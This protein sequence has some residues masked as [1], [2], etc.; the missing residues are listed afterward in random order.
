AAAWSFSDEERPSDLNPEQ[1]TLWEYPQEN[2]EIRPAPVKQAAQVYDRRQLIP[3]SVLEGPMIVTEKDATTYVP[4]GWVVT[5][6]PGGYLRI[7]KND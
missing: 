2:S 4:T 5:P 7:R 3:G 1:T 6:A